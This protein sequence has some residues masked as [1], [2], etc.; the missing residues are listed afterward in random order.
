M[1]RNYLTAAA[2]AVG[3]L[4]LVGIGAGAS[5]TDSVNAEQKLATGTV[6]LAVSSDDGTVD[7]E[8][9]LTC[10]VAPNQ[11]SSGSAT[12]DVTLTNNGT[13]PITRILVAFKGSAADAIDASKITV[14]IG[15]KNLGTL[16]DLRNTA[17]A[18]SLD[19]AIDPTKSL[20][21]AVNL[22]WDGLTN[23]DAGKAITNAMTFTASDI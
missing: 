8:D 1:S 9:Q 21:T 20:T 23:D 7:T 6:D 4:G 10:N 15:Q 2:L 18:T 13:L 11:P 5:F 19:L 22:T 3:A 12:C 16:A 17:G 14:S